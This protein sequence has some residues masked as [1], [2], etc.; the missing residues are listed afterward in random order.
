MT[1]ESGLPKWTLR[2]KMRANGLR[3]GATKENQMSSW[4]IGDVKITR[5]QEQE[6]VWSGTMIL[7]EAVADNVKREGPWL[8]PFCQDGSFRLSI[9]ALLVE[10]EGKRILVDT[11]VGND[12]TRPGFTDWSHL[13]LPFIQNMEK[14]GVARDSIDTV[15]CTHLHL[16]HV[17]WNTTLENGKW[18]PTFP[19][20]KYLMVKRE[21]EHW[22]KYDGMADFKMT[23]DDSVR[24]VIE[25]GRAELI[26]N[27]HRLTGDV[28]LEATPG[29]TPGHTS[30]RIQSKGENA[31]ITG[32]MIHHP[33]QIA[34]PD[35]ICEFDTDP[36][37]ASETRQAFVERYCDKPVTVL[38]TH[39]AGPTAGH[40][41]RRNA[42][43]RFEA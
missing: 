30:V 19:K 9:H 26:D 34:H 29:H 20:A 16:D 22:N 24:P 4:K 23:I 18:V 13:H 39:F 10:T 7:K 32:D 3:Q 17:G 37:M 33:I 25:A 14:A 15:L 1:N 8:D 6:P 40:I 38:G 28:V 31:V 36:Q 21:W 2:S 5:F 35:W 27:G 11:C 42:G 43:F 12:K 41:V